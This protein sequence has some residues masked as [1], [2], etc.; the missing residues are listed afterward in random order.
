MTDSVRVFSDGRVTQSHT[1][2]HSSPYGHRVPW[3]LRLASLRQLQT[4]HSRH[5]LVNAMRITYWWS[6]E[7][8]D[9][10]IRREHV[11][12]ISRRW[13]EFEIVDEFEVIRS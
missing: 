3:W 12:T 8:V 11:H 5:S 1:H 7:I 9:E 13:S 10:V 4:A 2:Y 6:Q